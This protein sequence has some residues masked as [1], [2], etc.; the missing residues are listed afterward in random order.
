[1]RFMTFA[2]NKV[3]WIMDCMRG[4][5]V[6]ETYN[7]IK[8]IDEM[9]SCN[10]FIQEYQKKAWMKLKDK[11]CSNTKA[12]A[13]YSDRD[14]EQFPMITKQ[15]IRQAQK[16]YLSLEFEKDELIQMSTSGSTGTPFVCYQ[17][18]EKKRKVNAEIIYYSEKVGYKLGENLSYIRTV[19]KQN[20]K[21]SIKQFMQNQT[22]INCGKLG[23]DGVKQLLE[24]LQKQ[25]KEAL[26]HCLLM[27]RL[28]LH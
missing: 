25:S 16:D 26:L 20:K 28:I 3:F 22:L 19:V 24:E 17:N 6:R 14:F 10:P 11:A 27:D 7:D 4:S 21:S 23:E 8:K 5:L 13:K 18:A 1:M 15:D 9:D 12:Y 2:R